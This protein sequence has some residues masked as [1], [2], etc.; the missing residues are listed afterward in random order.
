MRI[1]KFFRKYGLAFL[2]EFILNIL[3]VMVTDGGLTLSDW[4]ISF[5]FTLVLVLLFKVTKIFD[6]GD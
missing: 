3:L 6:L 4:I 1:L 5:V 2:I